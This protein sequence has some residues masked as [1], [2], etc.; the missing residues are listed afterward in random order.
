MRTSTSAPLLL[1]AL[2]AAGTSVARAILLGLRHAVLEV[3]DD[4]IRAARVRARDELLAG[5]RHE[6]QGAPGRQIGTRL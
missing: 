1:T 4:G 5:H 2:A 6:Q 3:E